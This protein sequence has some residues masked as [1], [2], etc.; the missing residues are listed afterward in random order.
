MRL[1]IDS[2]CDIPS[3]FLA[4]YGISVL[5]LHV[6]AEGNEYLDRVSIST[7]EVYALMRRGVMPKTSQVNP[8]EAEE[9]LRPLVQA[10]EDVLC[11]IFSAKMSGTYLSVAAAVQALQE[12][13][14]AQKLV[15]LDA[16]GGSFATG[17]IAMA[18]ARAAAKGRPFDDVVALCQFLIR[19]VEHVFMVSDL[20]WMIRGGRISKVM[21]L[22]ASLLH[23][24]PILDV[25]D[26]AMEVIQKVRGARN[27]MER[28][29]DIVAERA[30]RCLSQTIGI[31][32]ADDPAA[33]AALQG[34][35]RA[36]LPDCHFLTEEIGAVLGVHLGI[37]GVGA[38]FFNRLPPSGLSPAL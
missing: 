36:R 30:R 29:A 10:G 17:L 22:T 19:H 8:S 21:G 4:Q 13:F 16:K 23:I 15:A 34:L 6:T 28:V 27:A 5:P 14:P 37:G 12:E 24:K 1:V 20:Q 33:A 11:L 2:T 32:H 38:F 26:G 7:S 35:L 3:S 9:A 25:R 31:T 18:A